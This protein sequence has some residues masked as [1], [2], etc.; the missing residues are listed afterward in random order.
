MNPPDHA[1]VFCIDEKS[2]EMLRLAATGLAFAWK[3]RSAN[4]CFKID[5]YR[6]GIAFAAK[7]KP[8]ARLPSLRN[9][10]NHK[11]VLPM[12]THSNH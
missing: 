10:L 6:V 8:S 5:R 4:F 1:L 3:Q 2:Q 9:S 7:Q 12:A 11:T